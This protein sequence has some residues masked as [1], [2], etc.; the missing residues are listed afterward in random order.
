M[1][2]AF[3]MITS[4]PI[5]I[6][7]QC[8][9]INNRYF[10]IDTADMVTIHQWI[11]FNPK[12]NTYALFQGKVI[13]FF[14]IIPITTECAELFDQQAIKEEDL[15]IEHI[16]APDV[17]IH[18]QYAYLAAIAINDT[19]D[20]LSRQCAAALI[21]TIANHF[22]HAYD[23]GTLKR[24]YANPTTFDGNH[25]VRKLG[26]KP[27]V[28]LKKPLTGNDIYA[29]DVTDETLAGFNYYSTRY[30]QFIASTPWK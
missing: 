18:A 24:I 21:T 15:A 13:G 3:E 25:M 27:V 4:A 5:D 22:L 11:N 8:D 2:N 23:M 10:T 6:I 12:I 30:N 20:F 19:H 16:L 1:R 17:M 28:A 26:L 9:K 7:Y 14:N 29:L